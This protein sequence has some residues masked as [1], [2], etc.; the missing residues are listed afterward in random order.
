MPP[1]HPASNPQGPRPGG[2]EYAESLDLAGAAPLMPATEVA[3]ILGVSRQ[4]VYR[5]IEEGEIVAL[6]L[7]SAGLRV[8]RDSVRDFAR[9]CAT[10]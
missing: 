3:R 5:L 2:A 1:R 4:T 10:L 8:Y 9:R 6:R 7:G